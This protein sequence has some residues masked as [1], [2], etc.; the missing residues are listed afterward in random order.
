MFKIFSNYI[1]WINIQN[2][3]LEVSGAV[4]PLYGSLGVKGLSTSFWTLR[5]PLADITFKVTYRPCQKV[6]NVVSN[7]T[8]YSWIKIDQLDVSCFIISLF[9]AQHVSNVRTSILRSLR[10]ICWVISWVVLLWYVVFWC[11]V[12]VEY[13]EPEQ[14]NPWNNS[15]NKLQAPEDGCTNIR[16]MLRIKQWNNKGSDI[17]LASLYSTIKMMRGPI[18]IRYLV[19]LYSIPNTEMSLRPTRILVHIL[20]SRT[21]GMRT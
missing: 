11:Y 21:Q 17:K 8:L 3:T 6:L 20:E 12:M 4:R 1:C 2:G 7:Y 5:T 15:T 10:L 18:N 16:N 14:Y 9:N 19:S 13:I